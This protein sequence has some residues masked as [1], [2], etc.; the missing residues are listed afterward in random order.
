MAQFP[1]TTSASDVWALI[2]VYRARAGNNWPSP[3]TVPGAPTIGTATGGNAQATVTFTAPA[4]DGGSPI[5]GY[6]VTSS[7]GGITATGSSSP[8]TITGL[9]NGTAYTFTVAAQ[10]AIGYGPE[11]A[12]S[13][14][15]TPTAVNKTSSV[16][17]LVVAGGGAG[18]FGN[19]SI[20]GGGGGAGGLRT[21]TSFAVTAG[22]QSLSPLVLEQLHNQTD[23]FNRQLVAILFSPQLHLLAAAAETTTPIT[24]VQEIDPQQVALEAAVQDHPILLDLALQAKETMAAHRTMAMKQAAVAV[25]AP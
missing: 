17:Y 15:V 10:N 19:S 6:R 20:G 1:S 11:S 24:I 9:T 23:Q 18:G 16:D 25:Q 4:S 7:P 14:S 2:D 12:A 21:A 8:I 3:T 13:N 22:H 5:T